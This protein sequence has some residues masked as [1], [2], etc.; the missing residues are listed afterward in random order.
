MQ[1]SRRKGLYN[2]LKKYAERFE[3]N[4]KVRDSYFTLFF[5]G[6]FEIYQGKYLRFNNSNS[7]LPIEKNIEIIPN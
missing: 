7:Q 1:K 6:S 2:E 5:R 4:K 3:K